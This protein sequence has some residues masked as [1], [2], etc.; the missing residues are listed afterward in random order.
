M[1][2]RLEATIRRLRSTKP[3]VLNLTNYVTMDF[4]AN[5]LLALGAPP[6]MTVC[7]EELEELILITGSINLNIGTLNQGFIERCHRVIEI[8]TRYKKPIILDPVGA[9]ASQIRTQLANQLIPHA[10]IVRGNASEIMALAHHNNQTLGVETTHTPF[11]AKT[12][13]LQ[14]AK[15]YKCTMVVSG[16]VDLITDG[17]NE[18]Q[19]PYGSALMP[20]VTGMGCTLTAIIAAFRG[21]ASNSFE[22]SHLATLYVGLCGQLAA[23]HALHPA[24]FRTAFIDTLHEANIE[25]LRG[26][27]L[28]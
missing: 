20:L 13:A 9:G 17:T 26:I 19:I 27:Y 28:E 23:Q 22:A 11:E 18:I 6:M 3:L 16:P 1:L 25:K 8:A 7:H 4:M 24:S 2:E 5:S 10:A 14:L 12:A 15:Q 21:I